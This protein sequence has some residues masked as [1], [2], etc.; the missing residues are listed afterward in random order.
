[1]ID[2]TARPEDWIF[3]FD[4]RVSNVFYFYRN[5]MVRDRF[6]LPSR[7]RGQDFSNSSDMVS[8]YFAFNHAI[9]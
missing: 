8:F 4:G 2:A 3:A 5:S 9:S 7:T 6:Y 1:M